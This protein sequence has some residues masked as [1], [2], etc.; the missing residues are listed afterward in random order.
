VNVAL[1]RDKHATDAPGAAA[2]LRVDL[3]LRDGQSFYC[4]VAKWSPP[5]SRRDSL[6][7]DAALPPDLAGLRLSRG[8]IPRAAGSARLRSPYLHVNEQVDVF[9]YPQVPDRVTQ[10]AWCSGVVRGVVG[11]NL[12]QMD[13]S[14]SGGLQSQ[15]GYS[16][17]PVIARYAGGDSVVGMACIASTESSDCYAISA[18]AIADTWSDIYEEWVSQLLE[19]QQ[20]PSNFHRQAP[21]PGSD[22]DGYL[23]RGFQI[24]AHERIIA[25][26]DPWPTMQRVRAFLRGP[27]PRGIV[28]SSA[29]V[30]LP[31]ACRIPYGEIG[32]RSIEELIIHRDGVRGQDS[33]S[34]YLHI[35]GPGPEDHRSKYNDR[36]AGQLYTLQEEISGRTF[37]GRTL[38]N[39]DVKG[40]PPGVTASPRAG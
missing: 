12:V 39:F 27:K 3:P 6:R 4:R 21:A 32:D 26:W 7:I 35:T 1:G 30:Y 38:L 20:A 25:Y 2:E 14:L 31:D 29:A 5:P 24:P 33:T 9:G 16:G 15:P 34:F 11:S 18:K 8:T 28:Y 10:G 19:H 36:I 37:R 13:T 40:R 23:R 22:D 17:S